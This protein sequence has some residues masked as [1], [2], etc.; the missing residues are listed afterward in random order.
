V[1]SDL[2]IKSPRVSPGEST[3]DKAAAVSLDNPAAISGGALQRLSGRG[4]RRRF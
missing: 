2:E 1:S 4:G 3:G